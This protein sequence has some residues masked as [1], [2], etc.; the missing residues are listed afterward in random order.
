MDKF[1]DEVAQEGSESEDEEYDEET[2]EHLRRKDKRNGVNGVEDSSEEEDDDLD[3]EAKLAGAS[4]GQYAFSST[5]LSG[6]FFAYL[7]LGFKLRS[8]I[9]L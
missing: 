8:T 5:K 4:D 9:E 6:Q 1:I 7:F 2:G 3:E